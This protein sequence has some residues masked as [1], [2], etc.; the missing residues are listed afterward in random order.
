MVK[1]AAISEG[2]DCDKMLPNLLFAYREVPQASTGFSPFELLYGR[3]VNGPLD[4]L[5][6]TWEAGGPG[7]HSVVSHILSISDKLP[8]MTELMKSNFLMP[9][10]DNVNAIT[11][12]LVLVSL[13][14]DSKCWCFFTHPVV[15]CLLNGKGHMR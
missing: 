9:R 11:T 7:E 4:V 1:K 10:R 6:N 8:K 5:K 12:M 2:K 13:S 14:Q 3:A 15:N